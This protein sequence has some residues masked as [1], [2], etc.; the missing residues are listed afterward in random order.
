MNGK[1][2]NLS[3]VLILN[4]FNTIPI[5]L[6]LTDHWDLFLLLLTVAIIIV[7]SSHWA[8]VRNCTKNMTLMISFDLVRT[9]EVGTGTP[10][11]RWNNWGLESWAHLP[12]TQVIG[13]GAG[14]EPRA[15]W[16][17]TNLG[18]SCHAHRTVAFH[19]YYR[20]ILS[21]PS[22]LFSLFPFYAWEATRRGEAPC[23]P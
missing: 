5:T 15:I 6:P 18:S 7:T 9:P 3:P 11:Y 10:L 12:I 22:H 1:S 20:Y 4:P 17:Q 2:L 8:L 13:D 14:F 23:P 19:N 21:W 16:S